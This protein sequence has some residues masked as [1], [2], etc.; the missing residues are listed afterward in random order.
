M[1]TS[2]EM[3]TSGGTGFVLRCE[4]R[5]HEGQIRAMCIAPNGE[6]VTGAMD[7]T[8]RRWTLPTEAGAPAL[9]AGVILDHDHWVVAL[10][11]L[12]PG[13]LAECPEGGVVTG[14]H[15]KQI[16][17]YSCATDAP[18]VRVRLLAGHTGGVISL[19]WTADG[20][21]LSGSWDGT[22]KVGPA[23]RAGRAS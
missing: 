1:A 15:D 8:V 22:A 17:V 4:L 14:C 7:A 6:L 3:D 11:A 12:P 2:S 19:G 13:A 10:A 21:L 18:A 23:S 9:E 20:R 5:G 16:R